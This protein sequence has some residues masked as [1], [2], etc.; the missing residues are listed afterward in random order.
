MFVMEPHHFGVRKGIPGALC[1]YCGLVR[2]NNYLTEF[3]IKYGCNNSDHPRY[4][5]AV[6]NLPKAWQERT[7]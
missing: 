1:L 6:A 7:R 5:W 2:A 3:A 4:P